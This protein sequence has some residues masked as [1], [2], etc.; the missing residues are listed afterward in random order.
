MLQLL[1]H[2]YVKQYHSL[3]WP[4]C[5]IPP[6][7]QAVAC[8]HFSSQIY[9]ISQVRFSENENN[10]WFSLLCHRMRGRIYKHMA[11]CTNFLYYCT[12][13]VTLN[14]CSTCLTTLLQYIISFNFADLIICL[15][16][17]LPSYVNQKWH[18][19]GGFHPKKLKMNIL[20]WWMC[21]ITKVLY[22]MN[23]SKKKIDI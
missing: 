22:R 17:V 10:V 21:Y 18:E 13:N 11:Y 15:T 4:V 9:L 8:I 14:Y 19:S 23:L 1:W 6:V 16:F 2:E 12:L 5:S 7:I 3:A 20:K